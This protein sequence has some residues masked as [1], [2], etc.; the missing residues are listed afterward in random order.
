MSKFV[1]EAMEMAF[2]ATFAAW[3][4]GKCEEYWEKLAAPDIALRDSKLD[5][6]RAH[7]T[8][9]EALLDRMA[10]ALSRFVRP[11]R[12]FGFD[13]DIEAALAALTAYEGS[14]Q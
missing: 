12:E 1:S 2:I 5:E 6:L 9:R 13:A 4:A 14:K 8:A 3:D 10:E 7:L 11:G